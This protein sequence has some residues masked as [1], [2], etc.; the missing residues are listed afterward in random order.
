MG[1]ITIGLALLRHLSGETE[2]E[3]TA[4]RACATAQCVCSDKGGASVT[5]LPPTERE[6][7]QRAYVQNA[8]Q[9]FSKPNRCC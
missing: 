4:A 5:S 6:Q 1:M 2:L 7:R 9:R 3:R 8:E